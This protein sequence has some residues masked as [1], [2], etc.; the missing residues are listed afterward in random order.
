M[1]QH[2]IFER[3]GQIR[4]KTPRDWFSEIKCRVTW[5]NKNG[6]FFRST[7]CTYSKIISLLF[8][9]R[10]WQRRQNFGLCP[11]R[12]KTTGPG[13]SEGK[14][15]GSSSRASIFV[16]AHMIP[17]I[18][19]APWF[20]FISDPKHVLCILRM[21]NCKSSGQFSRP[22]SNHVIRDGLIRFIWNWKW[23]SQQ[24]RPWRWQMTITPDTDR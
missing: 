21:Y 10:N 1:K 22:Q 24:P 18:S 16:V 19:F 20:G 5:K 3:C 13:A 6:C 14:A 7:R 23:Q 17:S 4:R 15:A 8:L 12:K 2:S 9:L 11:R